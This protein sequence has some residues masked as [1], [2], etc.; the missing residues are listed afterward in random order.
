MAS[1]GLWFSL[2]LAAAFAG[3][4][5]ALWPWPQNIQTS[6][7]RYVLYPN[8]FQFQYDVSSAAQ[9]GCS[10]LDEAFRRYRDLLFGSGS[11]PRPYLTES[12]PGDSSPKAP[13]TPSGLL[14]SPLIAGTPLPPRAVLDFHPVIPTVRQ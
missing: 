6:D 2:L 14:P 5:T 13:E 3:R 7:R 8:N 4:V 11:W 9:P 1:S 10:V 12:L